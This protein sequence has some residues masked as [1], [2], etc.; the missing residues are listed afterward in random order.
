MKYL[1]SG[2]LLLLLAPIAQAFTL[3]EWQAHRARTPS[4]LSHIEQSRWFDAQELRVHTSGRLLFIPDET[5]IWQ[6]LSPL[7]AI[8]EL[9]AAGRFFR[10]T[11]LV[12][13]TVDPMAT[14][15][16]DGLPEAQQVS[17]LLLAALHG[18]TGTL[19]E[20]YYPILSGDAEQWRLA[21]LPRRTGD[22][23]PKLVTLRGGRFVE[24]INATTASGN[25]LELRLFEHTPLVD[26]EAARFFQDSLPSP[27]VAGPAG[28]SPTNTNININVN[29]DTETR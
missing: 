19:K 8:L 1:A 11:P 26:A 28:V 3:E 12:P 5:M 13:G 23:V 15:P 21:L 22:D 16:Q 18:D 10:L 17:R 9:D 27:D 2:L 6:W 4:F 14:S 24:T 20:D 25:T 29:A 7:Q